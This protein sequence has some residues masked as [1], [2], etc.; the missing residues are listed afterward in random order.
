MCTLVL[1]RRPA[2]EWPVLLAANRD[3]M[4]DRPSS[5]PARHWPDR[6]DVVAGKD[7]LSS[8]SWLGLNDHGVVAAILNRTGS[9][10]PA[11]NKRSRGE[12]VLEALDHADARTAAQA[13]AD[14]DPTAYRSFNLVIADNRDGYWLAA[15][16][17]A[18]SIESRPIPEG[19][20]VFTSQD[21]NEIRAPRIGVYLP[22][23]EAAA[24][25]DP[26]RGEWSDW[27]ALMAMRLEDGQTRFDDAMCIVTDRGYGTV[28]SSLIA[29][30]APAP[31]A[32]AR[33]RF[34]AGRPDTTPYET[35]P[36]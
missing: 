26:A 19:Y 21:R 5:P 8:G 9:L 23:F 34:A 31:D 29:L 1:L 15:R 24:I 22:R 3:E 10:G 11:D 12:L 13:L 16:N 33:W 7:E 35:V 25:P 28:S 30:P 14:I 20:S 17:G 6:P 27:E 32:R 18:F 36:L 4:M 2:H